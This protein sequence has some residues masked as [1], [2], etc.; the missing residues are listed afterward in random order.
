MKELDLVLVRYLRTRWSQADAQDRAAF[1][2]I[3]ELP[4]PLLAACLM[5]RESAPRS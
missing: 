3:L 1:E 5:G 4:D 2:R